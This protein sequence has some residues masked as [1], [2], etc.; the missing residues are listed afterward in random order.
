MTKS[1]RN[2]LDANIQSLAMYGVMLERERVGVDKSM[3]RAEI[4]K[5]ILATKG[6]ISSTLDRV[7]VV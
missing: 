2:I 7:V 1:D 3:P 6:A 5:R 4:V